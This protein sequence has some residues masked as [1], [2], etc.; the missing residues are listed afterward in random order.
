MA[1]Y[2]GPTVAAHEWAIVRLSLRISHN[3]SVSGS[4]VFSL[5]FNGEWVTP[6]AAYGHNVLEILE[7]HARFL[8]SLLMF[9]TQTF[10]ALFHTLR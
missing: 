9:S 4:T 2:V 10:F 8:H 7:A 1:S 6:M 3:I 5:K